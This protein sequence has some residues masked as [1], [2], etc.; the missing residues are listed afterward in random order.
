[1]LGAVP[2]FWR[3]RALRSHCNVLA[4]GH[5]V[6][7]DELVRHQA[8]HA[9]DRILNVIF[10][11][12]SVFYQILM[13]KGS[14]LGKMSYKNEVSRVYRCRYDVNASLSSQRQNTQQILTSTSIPLSIVC[15]TMALRNRL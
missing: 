11:P 4:C 14:P 12:Q 5:S 8:C 13:F 1:M 9:L 2:S 7:S 15:Y 3:V 10:F 6:F